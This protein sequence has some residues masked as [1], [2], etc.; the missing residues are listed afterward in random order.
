MSGSVA[1]FGGDGD[2][3]LGSL[4]DVVGALDELLRDQLGVGGAR[5]GW[6]CSLALALQSAG[7]G[8]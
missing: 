8:G 3:L 7:A 5:I 2:E 4:G 1:L 6:C